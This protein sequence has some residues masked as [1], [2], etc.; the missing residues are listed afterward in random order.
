MK[1]ASP[2]PWTLERSGL[3]SDDYDLEIYNE[4]GFVE[5]TDEANL[6]HIV[7]CVNMHADLARALDALSKEVQGLISAHE[8][9]LRSDH[10][11]SNI[12]AVQ[13]RITTA[14]D[15]LAKAEAK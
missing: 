9:T 5:P 12:E 2:R 14:R 15:L 11:N 3:G 8:W 13:A 4:D 6:V 10:G 1:H 7:K